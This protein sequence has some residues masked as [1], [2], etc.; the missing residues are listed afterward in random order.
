MRILFFKIL[1][2]FFYLFLGLIPVFLFIFYYFS[3]YT[4]NFNNNF[5][6]FIISTKNF[7]NFYVDINVDL[8]KYSKDEIYNIFLKNLNRKKDKKQ[9]LYNKINNYLFSK[10]KSNNLNYTDSYLFFNEILNEEINKNYFLKNYLKLLKLLRKNT[11]NLNVKINLYNFKYFKIN[12]INLIEEKNLLFIDKLLFYSL[13]DFIPN[14]Y[15]E[16]IEGNIIIKLDYLNKNIF[17]EIQNLE[18]KNKYFFIQAFINK[19]KLNLDIYSNINYSKD[20]NLNKNYFNFYKIEYE[21]IFSSFP[22][23]NINF[24]L[25]LPFLTFKGNS[26]K[27]Y[28]KDFSFLFDSTFKED[29]NFYISTK[30]IILLNL[31]D[32]PNNSNNNNYNNNSNNDS[33]NLKKI[34]IKNLNLNL[35]FSSYG[36][37]FFKVIIKD[38][39]IKD[40]KS[41]ENTINDFKLVSRIFF[42]N[43][44]TN[45]NQNKLILFL[46]VISFYDSF[47]TKWSLSN[48]ILCINKF[49]YN[50]NYFDIDFINKDTK[51]SFNIK[52]KEI[53]FIYLLNDKNYIIMS[54]N[55]EINYCGIANL[56]VNNI[57]NILKFF[58][59]IKRNSYFHHIVSHKNLFINNSIY[60]IFRGIDKKIYK[61]YNSYNFSI[62]F[63]DVFFNGIFS[64]KDFNNYQL[65][66]NYLFYN[67]NIL[68]E[69]SSYYIDLNYLDNI[70][71]LFKSSKYDVKYDVRLSKLYGNFYF[72][73]ENNNTIFSIFSYLFNNFYKTNFINNSLYFYILSY[74]EI[75]NFRYSNLNFLANLFDDYFCGIVK[76]FK[77]LNLVGQIYNFKHGNFDFYLNFDIFSK[78]I[79]NLV[80]FVNNL[81][82]TYQAN[83]NHFLYFNNLFIKFDNYFY[84]NELGKIFYSNLGNTNL[85]N[86]KFLIDNFILS[87][88][89][90]IIANLSY[91][92]CYEKKQ[93]EAKLFSYKL[94]N[95]DL[96][97]FANINSFYELE[98]S[99]LNILFFIKQDY[100]NYLAK[101]FVFFFNELFFVKNIYTYF[102]L[103]LNFDNNELLINSAYIDGNFILNSLFNNKLFNFSLKIENQNG[104]YVSKLFLDSDLNFNVNYFKLNLFTTI[105]IKNLN[106]NIDNLLKLI[107]SNNGLNFS[108]NSIFNIL[109]SY[110]NQL[111]EKTYFNINFDNNF[112]NI[113]NYLEDSYNLK[114]FKF[115][116]LSDYDFNLI[117]TPDI[118]LIKLNS[119]NNDF[120]NFKIS[121]SSNKIDTFLYLD[122]LF[123]KNKVV[124]L[125]LKIKNYS[126]LF[127]PNLLNINNKDIS[128]SL[129]LYPHSISL[130]NIYF[131]MFFNSS[132]LFFYNYID[133]YDNPFFSFTFNGALNLDNLKKINKLKI[134][135]INTNI[136]LSNF[137][138]F[139]FNKFKVINL[140]LNSNLE[141]KFID[142]YIDLLKLSNNNYFYKILNDFI[143]NNNNFNL[144]FNCNFYFANQNIEDIETVYLSSFNKLKISLNQDKYLTNFELN[145]PFTLFK[146][147]PYF[148]KYFTFINKNNF[149]S[150]NINTSKDWNSF[151]NTIFVSFNLSNS[152]IIKSDIIQLIKER[153]VFKVLILFLE[154]LNIKLYGLYFYYSYQVD[155]KFLFNQNY[156]LNL[157][158]NLFED[159]QNFAHLKL[160]ELNLININK[161]KINDIFRNSEIYIQDFQ[162][163]NKILNSKAN[164]YLDFKNSELTL[165]FKDFNINFINNNLKINGILNILLKED[166]L[167][168]KTLPTVFFNNSI[169][170]YSLSFNNKM[171]NLKFNISNLKNIKANIF[172]YNNGNIWINGFVDFKD[173]K[174]NINIYSKLTKGEL[175][176]IKRD[177]NKN[178]IL[179]NYIDALNIDLEAKNIKNKNVIW[180]VKFD[181]NLNINLKD[182]KLKGILKINKGIVRLND[183]VYRIIQGN[184][185]WE[186]NLYGDMYILA[187]KLGTSP[188]DYKLTFIRGSIKDF[189]ISNFGL[190]SEQKKIGLSDFSNLN[191]LSNLTGLSNS[192]Y[193]GLSDFIGLDFIDYSN[194]RVGGN[195]RV[196][197][198]IIKNIFVF[199]L[200]K[201]KES[202]FQNLDYDYYISIDY[203]IK[204]FSKGVL[205]LNTS[206]YNNSKNNFGFIFVY[207]F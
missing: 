134:N 151:L 194:T 117:K 154:Q 91:F 180:D 145:I 103:N 133:N 182:T 172:D 35:L 148:D 54:S 13:L 202:N 53:D 199:Y 169:V 78:K 126:L 42:S 39:I 26:Y 162:L 106:R 60:V 46:D 14:D 63:S 155:I 118:F 82:L 204:R 207:G 191:S 58:P 120:L 2:I 19:S 44:F 48:S 93:V 144:D 146:L 49:D 28:I 3:S 136:N 111:W 161:L 185:K 131:D 116:Y 192:L 30:Q 125:S 163:I 184:I 108:K 114:I 70:E 115:L 15:F 69:L 79:N 92:Y 72:V 205:L 20:L 127:F 18:I 156:S 102:N 55:K 173:N 7:N 31:Y 25:K 183:G 181:S 176:I 129:N 4:F 159:N 110:V 190:Y 50:N 175:K 201:L 121:L 122:Y 140:N 11:I 84:F 196:G 167:T 74:L 112:F 56:S 150:N 94:F 77:Y 153:N 89:T 132:F 198:E 107:K 141:L 8:S 32:I 142:F 158:V 164:F 195:I 149:D 178:N 99:N 33:L 135:F 138:I 38:I 23:F 41:K 52:N 119:I 143:K 101:G 10:L 6:N 206:F 104:I 100:K 73:K 109:L 98:N 97:I 17:I 71:N 51:F 59:I 113:L 168:V 179:Y 186:N 152:Y 157:I 43:D 24:K 177:N 27:L 166:N 171:I 16:N 66:S 124:D 88:K 47:N 147:I 137:Y 139:S 9:N 160:N 85:K 188:F 128:L 68:K 76:D 75:N 81:N 105:D 193:L 61:D 67:L 40:S 65:F 95:D 189:V 203:L 96:K 21:F 174:F 200:R 90:L 12:L 86:L 1:K 83:N 87:K 29:C 170:N 62:I 165:S 36:F 187:Q 5:A 197:K 45:I 64:I 123:Y 34:D 80:L 37:N 22:V 130:F 57:L